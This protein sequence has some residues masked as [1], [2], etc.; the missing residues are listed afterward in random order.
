MKDGRTKVTKSAVA[1]VDRFFRG[2]GAGGQADEEGGGDGGDDD[3]G[4]FLERG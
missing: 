2:F 3:G 4:R 1:S